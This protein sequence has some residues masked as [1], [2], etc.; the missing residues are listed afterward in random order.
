MVNHQMEPVS[1]VCHHANSVMLSSPLNAPAV[2]RAN[3]FTCISVCLVNNVQQAH[4][5]I[6]HLEYVKIVQLDVLLVAIPQL[7][8]VTFVQKDL[9]CTNL[10][11]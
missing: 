1:L 8:S 7:W 3:S 10:S 2:Q 6:P 11:V 9:L 4:M 5:Q